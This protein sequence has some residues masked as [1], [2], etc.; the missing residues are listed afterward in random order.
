MSAHL[1]DS[2]IVC[3]LRK[4][5]LAL[6]HVLT[7]QARCR[8]S[9]VASSSNVATSAQESTARTMIAPVQERLQAQC[10]AVSSEACQPRLSVKIHKP[11]MLFR[12]ECLHLTVVRMGMEA[13]DGTGH[14]CSLTGASALLGQAIAHE[15]RNRAPESG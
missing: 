14:Y 6:G 13:Q 9:D 2:T 10:H 7:F 5:P 3:G 1:S 4:S 11:K 12:S 15:F 8:V